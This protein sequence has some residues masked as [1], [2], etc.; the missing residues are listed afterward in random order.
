MKAAPG[1]LHVC[2]APTHP[3]GSSLS[4]RYRKF[5]C[6]LKSDA[7]GFGI[8]VD[9][10]NFW[11]ANGRIALQDVSLKVAPGEL[12]MLVGEN[13]CGK[14]TLLRVIRGL[15]EPSSGTVR[16]KT[17]C[18]FV[19]QN[20]DI[21]IILPSIGSDIAASVPKGPNT[22]ARDIRDQVFE[23]MEAVGLTPPAD[24]IRLSSH[25]LSGGQRQR[26]VV[27]S[28][29]AMKPSTILFDEVTASMDPVNKAELVSRVR[30]IVSERRIAALWYVHFVFL[31]M[32][33]PL[34]RI[35]RRP[36]GDITLRASLTF[37][38]RLKLNAIAIS[39]GIVLPIPP[40]CGASVSLINAIHN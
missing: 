30:K 25:R 19:H 12:T 6:A 1:F 2:F 32:L 23:V 13:G 18:A 36:P 5:T 9:N 37:G 17:P 11:W 24:Y 20:P 14:S 39:D 8:A 7:R 26:A 4:R 34:F 33:H 28:A 15:L 35:L 21:Q 27:A 10:V 22:S 3:D 40:L 38:C 31:F 16:L 29:L